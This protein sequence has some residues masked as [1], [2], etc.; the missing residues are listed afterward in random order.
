ML[1]LSEADGKQEVSAEEKNWIAVEKF[2]EE[3]RAEIIRL[4]AAI[5]ATRNQ[6]LVDISKLKE[7]MTDLQEQ[8]DRWH[9]H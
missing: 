4:D 7:T 3:T 6:E 9:P 2:S 1:G 5:K 8:V